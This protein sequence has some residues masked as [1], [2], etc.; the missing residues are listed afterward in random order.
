M[1]LE[2]DVAVQVDSDGREE[3]GALMREIGGYREVRTKAGDWIF[4]RGGCF[5]EYIR[6]VREVR[7]DA[8]DESDDD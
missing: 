7:R 5:E 3:I 8:E 6:H 4:R 1:Q 2:S